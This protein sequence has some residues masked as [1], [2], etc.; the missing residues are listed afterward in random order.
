MLIKPNEIFQWLDVNDQSTCII[1]FIS[2][3]TKRTMTIKVT[4][5]KLIKAGVDL[6]KYRRSCFSIIFIWW[7]IRGVRPHLRT[8]NTAE[9][10][11]FPNPFVWH[12]SEIRKRR[13]SK[14]FRFD[15]SR[16]DNAERSYLYIYS[17]I[18]QARVMEQTLF[19]H[20]CCILSNVLN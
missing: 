17:C 19:K 11:M 10:K 4:L 18:P 1:E 9:S 3:I 7:S 15:E 13:P 5:R 16:W 12:W 20:F 8:D 14:L 2:F 6:V